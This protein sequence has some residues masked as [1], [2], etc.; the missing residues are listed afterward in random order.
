MIQKIGLIGLPITDSAARSVSRATIGRGK[1]GNRPRPLTNL[2]HKI[3]ILYGRAHIALDPKK[4]LH[5]HFSCQ[6]PLAPRRS[7]IEHPQKY[8]SSPNSMDFMELLKR[9]SESSVL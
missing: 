3:L 2:G 6:I 8:G 7:T 1:V 9:C 5:I 4:L